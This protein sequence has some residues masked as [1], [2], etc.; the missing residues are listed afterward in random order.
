M[1]KQTI[2]LTCKFKDSLGK[3]RSINIDSPNDSI[4]TEQINHFMQTAID[5]DILLVDENQPEVS[6]ISIESAAI[7]NKTVEELDLA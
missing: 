1:L 2:T 3:S 4:T 7:T 5:T 6:L